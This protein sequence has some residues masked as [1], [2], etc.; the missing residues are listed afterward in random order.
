[1]KQTKKQNWHVKEIEA[2]KVIL[3]E[4]VSHIEES[5]EKKRCV[6]KKFWKE[7]SF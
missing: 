6:H 1:M 4:K 2:S 5:L 3:K 7:V